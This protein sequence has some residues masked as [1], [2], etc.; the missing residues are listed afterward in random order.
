MQ[1][2]KRY[3]HPFFSFALCFS[4]VFTLL[5]PVRALAQ[6]SKTQK[7]EQDNRVRKA[8]YE[9]ASRW[10]A[11]KVSKMVFDT[12]VTPHWLETSDRFWYSYETSQGKRF[13]LVD[14]AKKTKNPVFDNARMAAM[15]TNL[16]RIPYDAQHLPITTIR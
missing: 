7:V 11:Q 2:Y 8:N 1:Q 12:A 14:P 3:T 15:L 5:A 16:T 10:T 6:D 4:L 13:Y 9:L